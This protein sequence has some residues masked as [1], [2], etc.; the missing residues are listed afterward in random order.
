MPRQPSFVKS[1]GRDTDLYVNLFWWIIKL[2]AWLFEK[3]SF[4]SATYLVTLFA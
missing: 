3:I 1:D 4:I 2:I